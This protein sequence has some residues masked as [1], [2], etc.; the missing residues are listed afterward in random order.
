MQVWDR[1]SREKFV[2]KKKKILKP[3][4][5]TEAVKVKISTVFSCLN[6]AFLVIYLVRA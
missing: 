3:L 5:F 2:L 6:V 4:V 1:P